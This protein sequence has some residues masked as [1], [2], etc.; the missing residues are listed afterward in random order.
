[1]E[2]PSSPDA[3]TRIQ[4]EY[5]ETPNMRLTRAQLGRL[6]DLPQDVCENA[7]A[8]LVATGFLMQGTG[9]RLLRGGLGRTADA[10]LGP[11]ALAVA[12]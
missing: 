12:S 11:P 4:I 9:G 7:I 8:S 10:V 6:C 1:M 5:I 3:R 2:L